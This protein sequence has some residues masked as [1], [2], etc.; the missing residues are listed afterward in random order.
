METKVADPR[1]CSG[2]SQ[3]R[4][5]VYITSQCFSCEEA[6]LIAAEITQKFPQIITEIVNLEDPCASKPDAVFAVPTYVLNGR[7]LSLGN[8]YREQLFAKITDLLAAD[9]S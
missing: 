9:V 3:H 2:A 4:L 8:P 7:L 6:V 5:R 1:E